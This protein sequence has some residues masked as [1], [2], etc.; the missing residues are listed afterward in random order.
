M[1]Q[2]PTTGLWLL[3]EMYT[4]HLRACY[5]LLI[6]IIYSTSFHATEPGPQPF[7]SVRCSDHICQNTFFQELKDT[8]SE[9][10]WFLHLNMTFVLSCFVGSRIFGLVCFKLHCTGRHS[11]STAPQL[12]FNSQH[13]TRLV[14]SPTNTKPRLDLPK[15]NWM[16]CKV[17]PSVICTC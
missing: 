11:W 12:L 10:H 16:V 14:N 17:S 3:T 15:Q 9:M 4:D 6:A 13:W 7:H 5:L 2:L 8:C 1:V